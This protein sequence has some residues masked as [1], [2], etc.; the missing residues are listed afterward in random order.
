VAAKVE[1]SPT[2]I[3]NHNHGPVLLGQLLSN[4]AKRSKLHN[5]VPSVVLLEEVPLEEAIGHFVVIFKVMNGPLLANAWALVRNDIRQVTRIFRLATAPKS[6]F[7]SSPTLRLPSIPQVLLCPLPLSPTQIDATQI[8]TTV[9]VI[10]PSQIIPN[11]RYTS[12]VQMSVYQQTPRCLP[13][14]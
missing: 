7:Y 1:G 3:W 6:V 14:H 10:H 12:V 11:H 4:Y 8:I 13:D 5:K 2:G 9:P